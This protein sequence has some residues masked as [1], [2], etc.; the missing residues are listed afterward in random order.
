MDGSI[1]YAGFSLFVGLALGALAVLLIDSKYWGQ[2]EHRVVGERN[3]AQALIQVLQARLQR[4]EKNHLIAQ[5]DI[6][7][8]RKDVGER[9]TQLQTRETELQLVQAQLQTA[10]NE[11]E[12]LATNLSLMNEQVDEWRGEVSTLRNSLQTAVIENQLLHENLEQYNNQLALARSENQETCQRLA[13]AE[14]EMKHLQQALAE[15][16]QWEE[17]A[18]TLKAENELLVGQLNKAEI[19]SSE[20]KAQVEGTVQQL[21]ETQILRK[22]IAE[23][24]TRVKVAEK[25]AVVLQDKFGAMQ[26]TLDYTGKNQ[27]QLIRGIGPAYARRLNE[28]GLN[29]LEDLTH[30]TPEQLIEI[31]QPKKWQNAQPEAWIRE[32][33]AL[34]LKIDSDGS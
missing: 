31:L 12:Q 23:M 16:S 1:I 26:S 21:T 5:N 20:L 6:E 11:N 34:T 9:D 19:R 14:V 25:Q 24:E 15:A 2:R 30:S 17:R 3:K 7:D 29:T 8:L 13:V 32:A 18:G 10:N 33:K 22:K 4:A 28:A 27:L